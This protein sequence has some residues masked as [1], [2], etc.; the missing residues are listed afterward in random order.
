[1]CRATLLK[2]VFECAAEYLVRP[3]PSHASRREAL[4]LTEPYLSRL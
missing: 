3:A 4:A 1:M 2:I